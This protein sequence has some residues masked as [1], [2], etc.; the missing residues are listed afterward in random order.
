MARCRANVHQLKMNQIGMDMTSDQQFRMD[1]TINV[2]NT[3]PCIA[4]A[5]HSFGKVL[6]HRRIETD[7]GLK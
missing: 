6:A 2:N 5:K 3:T 4:I 7:F 1:V